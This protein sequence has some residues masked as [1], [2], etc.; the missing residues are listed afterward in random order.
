MSRIAFVG[1]L[2]LSG[3]GPVSRKETPEQYRKVLLSKLDN[4]RNTCLAFGVKTIIFLG[5]VFNNNTGITNSFEGEIWNSFLE[6]KNKGIELYTIVGNHDMFFQNEKEFKG[7]YLYKAFLT[8]IIKHLDTLTVDN[9]FIRGIDYN[10][11]FVPVED[12][13]Y[14]NICVAHT[15]YENERFGGTGNANLTY[16]KCNKLGYNAYVL[17]HDHIPYDILETENFKVVRPGSIT[18]GTSKT[19]N[20]YRKVMFSIF[21]SENYNWSYFE[22]ETKPGVEVFNEKVVIEKGVELNLEKLLEDFT[23]TKNMNVYDVIDEKEDKGKEIFGDRYNRI[24]DIIT[25]ALETEG[26]Y[27]KREYDF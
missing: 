11:D 2:H 10:Y 24:L 6:F 23:V 27:R 18:R 12:K 13:E 7:T 21:N 17:G 20:I 22:V 19:C 8:G 26:I 16:D 1:D 15:F 14:Y 9:V 25:S 3:E 4:I 5:D